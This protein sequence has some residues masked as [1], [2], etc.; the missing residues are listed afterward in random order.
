[1]VWLLCSI[2]SCRLTSFSP[3]VNLLEGLDNS[4]AL[5]L[6]ASRLPLPSSI[7]SGSL[8]QRRPS[9]GSHRRSLS[10]SAGG[11]DTPSH[12]A[13]RRSYRRVLDVRSALNTRIRTVACPSESIG[14]C[15]LGDTV[16]ESLGMGEMQGEG[17]ALCVEVEGSGSDGGLYGFL[18][19]SLQVEVSGGSGASDVEI[20]LIDEGVSFPVVLGSMDQFNF[21]YSVNFTG[22][23]IDASPF[24]PRAIVPP[25]PVAVSIF[26]ATSPSQRFSAKFGDVRASDLLESI[27]AVPVKEDSMWTRNVAIVV[28]GRPVKLG[29][30]G[31]VST[32]EARSLTNRS[33]QA[34]A[35]IHTPQSLCDSSPTASFSSRWN[36]TIDISPFA[37]RAQ[38]RTASFYPSPSETAGPLP[39]TAISRF[40]AASAPLYR[41]PTKRPVLEAIAGSKRHT[42]SG[43]ASLTAKTAETTVRNAQAATYRS[44]SSSRGLPSIPDAPTPGATG[45]PRRFFSTS[46]A[47]ESSPVPKRASLPPTIVRPLSA[48]STINVPSVDSARKS[49]E[50]VRTELPMPPRRSF[51]HD[52]PKNI[53]V[54]IALQPLRSPKSALP[55]TK[56]D[57]TEF[58]LDVA[59]SSGASSGVAGSK[60]SQRVGLLD[61]FLVEVFVLNRGSTVKRFTIGVPVTKGG[62]RRDRI[63]SIVALDQDVRIGYVQ[64]LVCRLHS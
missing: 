24:A 52:T 10:L 45:P 17:M 9:A 50:I 46:P 60:R 38:S 34:A 27:P 8:D 15:G 11:I 42:I 40:A 4:F 64:S 12:P 29:E 54:S 23:P 63:A 62:R 2:D 43:L 14:N 59:T 32:G 5:H 35:V 36:C 3:D 41:Q 20:K 44:V 61:V 18:I 30:G 37:L 57:A 31:K 28:T 51:D 48:A 53:L 1:M 19:E 22:Q 47:P 25:T 6:P 58:E 55:P 13:I 16:G 21:L 39:A 26:A 56:E 33:K 49:A 7:A